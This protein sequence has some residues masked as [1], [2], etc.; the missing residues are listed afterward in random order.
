V[1]T[2]VATGGEVEQAVERLRRGHV[3]LVVLSNKYDGIDLPDDACRVLVID[4][5]PEVYGG[6]AHREAAVLGDSDS[7]FGR[8]MQRI[9][10]GMGRGVR[11]ANDYCVILLH[12]YRLT[13]KIATPSLRRQF[14]PL[15][16]AQ[17][18]LSKHVAN[19]LEGN[20]M[21]ELIE[22]MQQSL[23]RDTGWIR[24]S[25][26]AVAGVR[27]PAGHVSNSA[28][29]Q[30]GAFNEAV[31]GQ[32]QPAAS[33]LR[34][35]INIENNDG[36]RGILQEQLAVYTNF[37]DEPQAQ[38]VL[39]GALRTN[40]RVLRPISGVTYSRLPANLNQA[41]AISDYL[42]ERYS[43]DIEM[44]IGVRS[45][46]GDL[47][48][49]PDT[50][51]EFEDAMEELGKHLGLGSQRPERDLGNGP[52]VLWGVGDNEYLVI[53]CKSGATAQEISRKQVEQLMH[54]VAWFSERYDGT[55]TAK[56]ILV[57]PSNVMA[58]NAVAPQGCR[59]MTPSL[60]EKLCS[61]VL[62][63]TEALAASG[64]W[65]DAAS[66]IEQIRHHKLLG[67]QFA[68]V[69]AIPTRSHR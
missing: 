33:R 27:Y 37:F 60:I 42:T 40:P 66:V 13:Q 51:R 68:L 54:S 24:I 30:R 8:Q 64:S 28:Q 23:N 56:P 10:Q 20:S 2:I 17:L 38:Q 18:D 39:V 19:T 1:A 43:S 45:M 41:Q 46:I 34:D 12:G 67:K 61:S 21:H 44:L 11:S 69:H 22:V 52:D 49:D 26:E 50:T 59:V 65:T 58:S 36:V 7:L 16:L 29:A 3:G 35:A 9:E 63:M 25:R 53:E 15:T 48:F 31:V 4:G 57:H 6:I 55:N 14:S 47:V 5:L 62:S 32:F